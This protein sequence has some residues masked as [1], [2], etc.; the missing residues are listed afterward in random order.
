MKSINKTMTQEQIYN[1]AVSFLNNFNDDTVR[2]PAAIGY[3]I[4]KN[5]ATLLTFAQEIEGNRLQILNHYGELVEENKFHIP[6]ENIEKANEE[7]QNLLAIEEEI[8][9]Y[10]IK[11]EE[12]DDLMFTS[13][14][15]AALMFM[16]EEE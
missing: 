10:T 1:I 6:P 12:L 2:M 15:I 8:K 4:Q 3:A 14:Q 9:I 7:L 13:A 16:I 11:I 5:K